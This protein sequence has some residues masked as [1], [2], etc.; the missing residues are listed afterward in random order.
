VNNV[1]ISDTSCFIAYDSIDQLEILHMLFD[2]VC[3]TPQVQQE[4][5]RL[6][7][8]VQIKEATNHNKQIELYQLLDMGEASAIAL[9][10]ET[11]HS[12]IIIDEKKGRKVAKNLNLKVIGSLKVLLLA[13]QK[14]IISRV[15]PLIQALEKKNFRFSKSL[16]E[17]A[18][19]E[20]DE[21][22]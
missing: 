22:A 20:A 2:T 18:L 6:P 17:Q 1:I 16:V 14:G 12:I 8:W 21:L 15:Y 7:S 11:Q 5:G 19:K 13:K 9:A 4:F 10:L 3:T